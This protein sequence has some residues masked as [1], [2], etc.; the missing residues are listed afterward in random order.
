[1][2]LARVAKKAGKPGYHISRAANLPRPSAAASL[3]VDPHKVL[4]WQLFNPTALNDRSLDPARV[5]AVNEIT[6]SLRKARALSVL[7]EE[8]AD[9][10]GDIFPYASLEVEFRTDILS[11]NYAEP[12]K[13]SFPHLFQSENSTL[14][15]DCTREAASVEDVNRKMM[16]LPLLDGRNNLLGMI[17]LSIADGSARFPE[18]V[19]PFAEQLG[20][21]ASMKIENLKEAKIDH[22]TDLGNKMHFEERLHQEF[23]KSRRYLDPLSLLCLDIDYFKKCNDTYGHPFGDRVLKEFAQILRE[24][25]RSEVDLPMRVGGEEFAVILP[26]TSRGGAYVLAERI[27]KRVEAHLF[28]TEDSKMVPITVSIGVAALGDIGAISS[29]AD[30]I[31][32]AD[33]NLYKAKNAGRNRVVS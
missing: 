4:R 21:V 6:R 22:L 23:V 12:D 1:M 8:I 32:V 18:G 19:K 27:R 16:G 3:S 20:L 10:F 25:T 33:V 30:F 15:A 5:T 11:K 24:E 7:F 26:N 31:R 2:E 9:S 28:L 29:S 13:Q 17:V 14:M